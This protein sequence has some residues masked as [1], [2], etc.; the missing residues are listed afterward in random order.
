MPRSTPT[1]VV[2]CPARFTDGEFLFTNCGHAVRGEVEPMADLIPFFRD[3]E[4]MTATALRQA[5]ESDDKLAVD[6]GLLASMGLDV[7]K[8]DAVAEQ[9]PGVAVVDGRLVLE[10]GK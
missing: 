6:L 5:D 3:A 7:S 2:S 8:L 1:R 9:T 4:H 10:C